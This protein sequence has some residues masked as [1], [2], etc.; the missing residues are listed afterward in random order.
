[1][2][3]ER[4][5]QAYD[6]TALRILVLEK[7]LLIRDMLTQ[8]FNKFG[9]PT[10]QSTADPDIAFEM[11]S[12]FPFDVILSD[13]CADLDGIAFLQRVR[14]NSASSNP[15]IPV[16]IITANAEIHH[17]CMARDTGMTEYLA[18]PVSATMI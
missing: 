7:H 11:F 6:I 5:I 1:M 2:Q 3:K 10:V 4:A 13:W 14:D 15:F 8:V 18:K 12:Q 9:V 16:I 17:I